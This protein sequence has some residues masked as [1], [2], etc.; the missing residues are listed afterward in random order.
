MT[1][2]HEC[3]RCGRT[4]KCIEGNACAHPPDEEPPCFEC[5]VDIMDEYSR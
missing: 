3:P 5:G 4:F 1:V 2:T